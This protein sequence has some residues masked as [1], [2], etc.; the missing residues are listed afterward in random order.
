MCVCVCG[1]D[2]LRRRDTRNVVVTLVFRRCAGSVA[3]LQT[4]PLAH[5]FN[6]VAA[7]TTA[8]RPQPLARRRPLSEDEKKKKTQKPKRGLGALALGSQCRSVCPCSVF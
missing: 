2:E 3:L 4:R 1:E 8:Q 5:T 7:K 6:C